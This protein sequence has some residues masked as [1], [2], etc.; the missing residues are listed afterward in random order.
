MAS[1]T[2]MD[3]PPAALRVIVN[4]REYVLNFPEYAITL[5]NYLKAETGL[6]AISP[7][8]IFRLGQITAARYPSVLANMHRNLPDITEQPKSVDRRRKH[9]PEQ[10]SEMRR[11]YDGGEVT[12]RQLAKRFGL[13]ASRVSDI[14]KKRTST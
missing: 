7:D 3:G 4:V 2:G 14:L 8:A 1:Q 5:T 6:S 10:D 9:P 13:S 12:M 11:I